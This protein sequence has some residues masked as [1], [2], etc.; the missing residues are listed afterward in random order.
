[1]CCRL[2]PA[3]PRESWLIVARVWSKDGK[4][5]CGNIHF[6]PRS[7]KMSAHCLRRR[8]GT[9][10]KDL[11]VL[12]WGSHGICRLDRSCADNMASA[13]K[14]RPAA[15]MICWLQSGCSCTDRAEHLRAS[16]RFSKVERLRARHWAE[17]LP[18]QFGELLKC[19]RALRQDEPKEHDRCP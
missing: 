15:L 18:T 17:G 13:H 3:V 19:E 9:R 1:M 12:G 10:D 7:Q 16:R 6:D 14:G 8:P 5:F 11:P 2:P 4:E